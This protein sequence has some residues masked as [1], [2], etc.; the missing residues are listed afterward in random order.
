[1]LLAAAALRGA[2]RLKPAHRFTRRDLPA[3][4]QGGLEEFL[5][6]HGHHAVAE[7]DVGM[8]RWSDDPTYILGVLA[9]YRAA[10]R[11]PGPRPRRCASTPA[12]GP[13]KPRWRGWLAGCDTAAECRAVAV[14]IALGR[15]RELAGMRE[16]HKDYLVRCWHTFPGA[17]G[18]CR[19]R[20]G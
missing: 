15:V 12:V 8:L 9:N 14:R 13:L 18:R 4:L 17:V 6:Q 16:T 7:I 5:S 20:T 2:T 19:R 10:G 11:L 3:Q 1:M